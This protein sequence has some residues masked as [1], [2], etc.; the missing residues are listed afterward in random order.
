MEIVIEALIIAAVVFFAARSVW[1]SGGCGCSGSG[2][3]C[4]RGDGD[5]R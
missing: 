4:R 5:G 2:A 3:K 1:T